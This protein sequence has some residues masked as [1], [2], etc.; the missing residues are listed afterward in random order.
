[1]KSGDI[2]VVDAKAISELADFYGV[3]VAKLQALDGVTFSIANSKSAPAITSVEVRASKWKDGKPSRGRPRK[4]P[5]TTVARLLGETL[6]D[7]TEEV[8]AQVE[9]A[10]VETKV[11]VAET[12]EFDDFDSLDEAAALLVG[13]T[14]KVSEESV[15]NAMSLIP[16]SDSSDD[17]DD[18][19]DW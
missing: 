4:F 11:E 5:K 7:T 2:F 19:D 13:D 17:A 6:S 12:Q 8:V 14:P 16:G 10:K 18:G 15:Q 1:M 3:D 9:S